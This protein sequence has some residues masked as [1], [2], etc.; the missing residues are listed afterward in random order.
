MR[1]A[2]RAS[3]VDRSSPRRL[4]CQDECEHIII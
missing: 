4:V 2:R 1:E 3:L